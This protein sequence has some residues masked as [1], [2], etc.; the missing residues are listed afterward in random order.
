LLTAGE[1]TAHTLGIDVNRTRNILLITS[2]LLT[3]ATVACSGTIGF[4]GLLVPHGIRLITGANHRRLIPLSLPTGAS[5]MILTDLLARSIHPPMEIPVGVITG[6]L[7]A[8]LFL[9]LLKRNSV[10]RLG[11]N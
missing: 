3:A 5:L 11:S 7:G 6:L 4:V 9:V 10:Y 8:P 1:D 2:S